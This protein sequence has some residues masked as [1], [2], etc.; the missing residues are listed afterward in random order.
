MGPVFPKFFTPDPDPKE[1]RRILPESTPVIRSHLCNE[2][3]QSE[4]SMGRIRIGFLQDN[5]DF[6]GSGFDSDIYF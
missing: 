2:H 6:F 4:V 1:K 3:G 5:C